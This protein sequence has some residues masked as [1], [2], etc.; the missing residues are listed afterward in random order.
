MTFFVVFTIQGA[1][2]MYKKIILA[3]LMTF[4]SVYPLRSAS[5]ETLKEAVSQVLSTHPSIHGALADKDIA[6]QDEKEVRSG[7][8][9]VLSA[10]TSIGRIYSDNSTSRGLTVSRGAA[11]SGLWEGN[12]SITQPIY[13]GMETK[14]RIDAA[15]ARIQSAD[16][17]VLD[18]R[19]NLALQA[20]QVYLSLL[21]SQTTLEKIKAYSGVIKD[22]LERIQYMVDEGVADESEAA[23][24]RNIDLMLQT[25]MIDFEGQYN[26]ALANYVEVIGRSPN[27]GLIKP[28]SEVNVI[29]D[30]QSAISYAKENHPLLKSNEKEMDA[31]DYEIKAEKG[32]LYPSLDAELSGI[33]RDQ[34]EDIGGELKDGRALLKLSWDFETGG[35]LKARTRKAKAQHAQIAA[36]NKERLRTIEGDIQRAYAELQTAEK[37]IQLSR[38]RE[39]VTSDL[40]D[41]Y[42]TQFEGARVRLLQLM[43][44]ENQLFN[45]R[46]EVISGEYRYLLAQYNVLASIG[47]LQD[48]ITSAPASEISFKKMSPAIAPETKNASINQD[49]SEEIEIQ[50]LKPEDEV[51]DMTDKK[52]VSRPV[53][54]KAFE[55][56]VLVDVEG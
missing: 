27:S 44:A 18:V 55:E 46:L 36:E 17:R 21:Q 26:S 24:A 33:K 53:S 30:I 23:Q 14:N 35:A 56:R 11:Y 7:L 6:L 48:F 40:F 50:A 47:M 37:Q 2:F 9:P 29:E 10:S 38:K 32:A 45:A 42:K 34:R 41:A 15:H 13:D 49:I 12:A 25:T 52:Y 43:Q 19:E 5:S 3:G 28:V 1:L 20:T 31:L 16:Y 22:Y 4:A 39:V 54:K 8:F 51:Q